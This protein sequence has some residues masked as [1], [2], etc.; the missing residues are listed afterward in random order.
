MS[1]DF[2]PTRIQNLEKKVSFD[3]A[4]GVGNS[5]AVLAGQPAASGPKI[6]TFSFQAGI[7][8]DLPGDAGQLN[9]TMQQTLTNKSKGIHFGHGVQETNE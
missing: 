9:I 3:L 4:G 5:S 6:K 8:D 1:F 7:P 2:G